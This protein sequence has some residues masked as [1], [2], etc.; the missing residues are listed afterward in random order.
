[1]YE[2]WAGLDS[3][4]HAF[5]GFAMFF[6][7]LF[8]WQIFAALL[9]LAGHGADSDLAAE[10][11]MADRAR[12]GADHA[13][14]AIHSVSGFKLVSVRSILAF[15]L[16]FFWAGGFYLMKHTPEWWAMS[17]SLLWGLGAMLIVSA[18]FYFMKKLQETGTAQL[19]SCIGQSGLVYGTIPPNGPGQV[20]TLVGGIV[21]L[22]AAR[23]I[24]GEAIKAGT[25]VRIRRCLDATTVEVEK[26]PE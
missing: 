8:V 5:F 13:D 3:L 4:T 11:Q 10:T 15:F 21:T 19:S 18:M 22:V 9:G 2:W 25:P 26:A 12:G 1:M 24:G 20:R 17:Y 6:S 14:A 7:F 23:G 16:L